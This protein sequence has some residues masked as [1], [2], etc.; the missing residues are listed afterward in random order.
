MKVVKGRHCR[1]HYYCMAAVA[2]GGSLAVKVG[3]PGK[4]KERAAGLNRVAVQLRVGEGMGGGAW[5]LLTR[6]G[7]RLDL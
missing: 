6:V 4:Y 2:R 3:P 5:G 1:L 7:E